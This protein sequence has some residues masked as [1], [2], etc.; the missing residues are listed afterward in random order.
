MSKMNGGL[1]SL[2]LEAT[3]ALR[4]ALVSAEN[5]QLT[6]K[7]DVSSEEQALTNNH[8]SGNGEKP[9]RG[10]EKCSS[11]AKKTCFLEIKVMIF[12]PS[13]IKSLL[14]QGICF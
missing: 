11:K 13:K 10:Y 1:G 3:G 5:L 6:L 9:N 4:T 2:R 7:S 12:M 8:S 14:K